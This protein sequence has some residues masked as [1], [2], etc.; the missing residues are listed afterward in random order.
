MT[1]QSGRR[2]VVGAASIAR[3]SAADSEQKTRIFA[4]RAFRMP[5]EMLYLELTERRSGW[6]RLRPGEV[7][8]NVVRAVG[9]ERV[10]WS[11]LWP[12]SPDDVIELALSATATRGPGGRP[13]S[14]SRMRW[15][16]NSPPG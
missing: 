6:L 1:G 12:V 14:L 5:K 7:L 13:R 9:L 16:S 15:L 4:E 8:P 10:V 11:S 2:G 3:V